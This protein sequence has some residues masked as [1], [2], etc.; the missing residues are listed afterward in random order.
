MPAVIFSRSNDDIGDD[1]DVLQRPALPVAAALV[2]SNESVPPGDGLEYLRRVR[3]QAGGLPDVVRSSIDPERNGRKGQHP[4]N[5]PAAERQ[6]PHKLSL[7]AALATAAAVP[8]PRRPPPALRPRAAWQRQLLA[9]VATARAQLARHVAGTARVAMLPA[10]SAREPRPAAAAVDHALPE[11]ADASAWLA[12]SL[13]GG[14][15]GASGGG[16][17]PARAEAAWPAARVPSLR[18]VA[19][20]SASRAVGFLRGLLLGLEEERRR[21]VS[22]SDAADAAD[23][24]TDLAPSEA[25]GRWAFALLLRLEHSHDADTSSAVRALYSACCDVRAELAATSDAQRGGGCHSWV[26]LPAPV[27]RR[28][29]CLNLLI[30]MSAGIFEQAPREE[31]MGDEG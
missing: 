16:R 17:Q 7:S 23:A 12:W 4:T 22:A 31:W 19:S 6:L 26:D 15:R 3:A 30:T 29:A 2:S 18:L 10:A 8:P 13:G 24:A 20:L 21:D 25:F 5:K 14:G 28:V 11:A 9:D 27:Q 1:D